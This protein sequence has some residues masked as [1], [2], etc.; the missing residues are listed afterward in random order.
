MKQRASILVDSREK[1]PW[2]FFGDDDFEQVITQKLDAGDYSLLEPSGLIIIERKAS[3][4]ELFLNFS[5]KSEKERFY[6]EVE[7]LKQYQ[8][9]F[10]VI[11]QTL[12][13]L[14]NSG[15][16]YVNKRQRKFSPYMPPA[17][18]LNTLIDLMINHN[19]HV[20][21]ASHKGQ[22]ITKKLLL[23]AFKNVSK[24]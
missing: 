21:F 23:G 13:E 20:I 1:R 4:D 8:Y 2:D 14:M 11:E 16:Y 9:R 12:E 6:R 19:I 18:V 5:K 24:I 7:R 15:S 22:S 17:V 3:A 10:I